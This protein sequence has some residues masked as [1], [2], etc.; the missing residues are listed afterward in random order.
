MVPEWLFSSL[1]R[2]ATLI[3]ELCKSCRLLSFLNQF[4][5]KQDVIAN[6]DNETP[7]YKEVST[8]V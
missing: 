2:M 3:L 6:W 4:Y 7:S 1:S 5:F 8:K